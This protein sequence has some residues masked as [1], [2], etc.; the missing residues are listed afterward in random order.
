MV[1]HALAQTPADA[2]SWLAPVAAQYGPEKAGLLRAA[3][4]YLYAH[5]DGIV[6]DSG[7]PLPQHA[8][9]TAAILAGMRFDAETVAA[10]LL[11]GLPESALEP[12]ALKRRFGPGLTALLLGAA[13]LNRM[14]ALF[15]ELAGETNQSESLRQMLLAMTD[16][17][18]VVLIKLAERVQWACAN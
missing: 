8:L 3:V 7:I 12:E 4:D 14:D 10:A 1:T 11:A 15:S 6:T 2:E 18:R 16:D 13:R 17:I 5:G 9:A